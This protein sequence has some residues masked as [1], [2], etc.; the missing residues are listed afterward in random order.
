MDISVMKWATGFIIN[1]ISTLQSYHWSSITK[2]SRF[3]G[4]AFKCQGTP[5]LAFWNS[6]KHGVQSVICGCFIILSW[7]ALQL[8]PPSM[9]ISLTSFFLAFFYPI[10]MP[11][12]PVS[13][14]HF[15]PIWLPIWPVVSERKLVA[16]QYSLKH[17]MGKLPKFYFYHWKLTLTII[18]FKLRLFILPTR[19]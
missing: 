14:W 16:Q 6:D 2:L 12:W 19:F 8:L 11:I 17:C 5:N 13:I 15:Y 7:Y 18:F 9:W 4:L 10:W 1:V 3:A